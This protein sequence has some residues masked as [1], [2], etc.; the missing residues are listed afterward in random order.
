MLFLVNVIICHYTCH[1][2]IKNFVNGNFIYIH[3]HLT[4]KGN[5]KFVIWVNHC[6]TTKYN[7]DLYMRQCSSVILLVSI[8][9]I[10]L[11]SITSMF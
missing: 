4:V 1:A 6:N 7:M 8:G 3:N 10:L 5:I 2:L 9:K 11:I